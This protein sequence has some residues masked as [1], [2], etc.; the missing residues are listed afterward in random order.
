MWRYPAAED[1]IMNKA[2]GALAGACA[3]AALGLDDL[4]VAGPAMARW[5]DTATAA[6]DDKRLVKLRDFLLDSQDSVK[7]R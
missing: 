5:R 1:L 3:L 7:I 2:V 6:T 4:G